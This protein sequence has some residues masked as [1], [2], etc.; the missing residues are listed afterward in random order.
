M[1]TMTSAPLAGVSPAS[2]ETPVVQ[3]QR[4]DIQN[5]LVI[6][7]LASSRGAFRAPELTQ[8][9]Q[10]FDRVSQFMQATQPTPNEPTPAS[11]TMAPVNASPMAPPF[12]PKIGG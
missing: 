9:G 5:L 12:A 10:V 1:T 4:A 3:L 6:I 11:P 2:S 7:D 8:I